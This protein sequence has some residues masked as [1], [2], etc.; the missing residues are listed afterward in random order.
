MASHALA[1][2]SSSGELSI[3]TTV[4]AFLTS[5]VIGSNYNA[6]RKKCKTWAFKIILK[7]FTFDFLKS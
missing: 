2:I 1:K 5:I 6:K 4:A 3:N 7:S